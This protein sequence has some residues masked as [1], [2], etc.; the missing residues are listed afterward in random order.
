MLVLIVIDT[1]NGDPHIEN[2]VFARVCG[3]FNGAVCTS[4]GEASHDWMAS[5]KGSDRGLY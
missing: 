1:T 2:V 4:D 5:V 3:L